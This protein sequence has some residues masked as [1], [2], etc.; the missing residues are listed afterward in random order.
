MRVLALLVVLSGCYDPSIDDCQFRCGVG[1]SC[2]DGTTCR[3]GFCRSNTTGACAN[4]GCAS[5]PAPPAS[6]GN[7]FALLDADGCGVV[8]TNL[9]QHDSVQGSCGPDWRAGILDSRAE[10]DAVPVT[11]GRYWVGAERVSTVFQWFSG[12][13]VDPS[14]W[15]S[16][17][18]TDS[19]N[20]VYLEGTRRRL[21]NDRS[22]D[23]DM[24]YICTY[25]PTN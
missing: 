13:P 7:K 15:D 18:P 14:A 3:S 22:C 2:P 4:D 16:N 17:N 19:G 23:E 12:A 25:P 5:A 6:C 9:Q 1:G 20:C 8:C 10:L 11:T 21:R 24:N